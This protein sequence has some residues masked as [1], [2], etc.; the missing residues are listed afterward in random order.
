MIRKNLHAI[1]NYLVFFRFNF[2][3]SKIQIANKTIKKTYIS[4]L[5]FFL[6]KHE[7][8]G[9][10]P[11]SS[12]IKQYAFDIGIEGTDYFNENITNIKNISKAVRIKEKSNNF[13][14]KT[15][16]FLGSEKY[17]FKMMFIFEYL[18]FEYLLFYSLKKKNIDAKYILEYKKF[19]RITK[20]EEIII[21]DYINI[22]NSN[23]KDMIEALNIFIDSIDHQYLYKMS[24]NIKDNIFKTLTYRSLPKYD[25]AIMGTMSAG[26]SSF[27]NALLGEDY[28]PA[29]NEACTT[30][31]TSIIDNNYIEDNRSFGACLHLD[32]K[33]KC[34]EKLS[35]DLLESWNID[36]D[37]IGVL[38][39]TDI[40]DITFE[41]RILVIHDTPGP[42]NSSDETHSIIVNNFLDKNKI[43]LFIY[44]LNAEHISTT[45]NR[46]FL[47]NIFKYV[48]NKNSNIIFLLN[49]I[50]SFDLQ[51]EDNIEV[52]INGLNKELQEIGFNDFH[53][54]PISAKSA[55]LFKNVLNAKKLSKK[56]KIEF[57]NAFNLFTEDD[58]MDLRK[59]YPKE[60][61]DD[62]ISY[63]NDSDDLVIVVNDREYKKS[64]I[65]Q[66]LDKTGI[67]AVKNFIDNL[68]NAKKGDKFYG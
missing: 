24:N 45:D 60:I 29:K 22:L 21:N 41:D 5:Y 9:K 8:F 46:E 32:G 12:A 11:I 19:F 57:N 10:V 7:N 33:Y 13:L 30:K 23:K 58:G 6:S 49:K 25:I 55:R 39:E 59:Y 67:M 52:T 68:E 1:D 17:I 47:E 36:S 42:N 40:K 28:I 4:M 35:S 31:I 2:T 64:D 14:S 27:I 26:K 15:I 61:I 37:V 38:I 56:E 44:L 54:F 53:I 65:L 51:K 66:L 16:P 43:D 34:F 20:K 50:D 18:F 62:I 48:S 3:N 63:D